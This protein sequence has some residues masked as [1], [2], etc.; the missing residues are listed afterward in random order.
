M[1]EDGVGKIWCAVAEYDNPTGQAV[2]FSIDDLE[3]F[4]QAVDACPRAFRCLDY[5]NYTL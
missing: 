5:F 2:A 4:T 3:H 1:P